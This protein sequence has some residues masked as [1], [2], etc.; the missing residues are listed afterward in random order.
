[1]SELSF[2]IKNSSDFL[3][4]LLEDY[5][6]FNKDDTSSRVAINCAMTAWHLIDWVYYELMT[7]EYSTLS[8]FQKELKTFCPELQIMQDI[9]H[10]S[11]HHTLTRH[12]PSIKTTNLHGGSFNSD[13]SSDFDISSLVIIKKDGTKLYFDEEIEKVINFWN[14]YFTE[15]L[16]INITPV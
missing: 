11:K 7:N 12:N 2:E 1:M 6:E 15:T 13:F 3:K 4:K 9:T 16:K 8:E 5:S 14:T 10:S